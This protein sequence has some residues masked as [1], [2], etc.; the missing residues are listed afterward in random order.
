MR[1]AHYVDAG[2][3]GAEQIFADRLQRQAEIRRAQIG[4]EKQCRRE[5]HKRH[6]IRERRAEHA[7]Q[8]NAVGPARDVLEIGV[9]DDLQNRERRG[10]IGDGEIGAGETQQWRQQQ[11][12][13]AGG[14]PAGNKRG[15]RRRLQMQHGMIE[16][17]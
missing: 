8:T 10:E 16:K 4:D 12:E 1:I 6:R 14:S 13:R 7:A 9:G 2:H 11:T 17:P 15:E 3:A 5:N